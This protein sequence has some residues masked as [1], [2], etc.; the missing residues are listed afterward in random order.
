MVS[1]EAV[2]LLMHIVCDT[3]GEERTPQ[4]ILDHSPTA[5]STQDNFHNTDINYFYAVM[6]HTDTGETITQYKKLVWDSNPEIWETWQT[7]LRKEI[8]CVV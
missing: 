7:G 6:T 4:D 1:Q 5:R 3:P 2:N 8:G